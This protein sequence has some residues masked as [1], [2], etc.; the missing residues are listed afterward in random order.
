MQHIHTP[1]EKYLVIGG[2][3]RSQSDDQSHY[4]P[5]HKLLQLYGLKFDPRFVKTAIDDTDDT[6]RGLDLKNFIVLR[7]RFD[8]N[9]G[10]N[11]EG[12][13]F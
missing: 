1:T 8:G 3:V 7:P 10:L 9:Y 4:V 13:P 6:L 11:E 5:A 12:R 2:N